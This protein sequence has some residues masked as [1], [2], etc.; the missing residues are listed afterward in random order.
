MNDMALNCAGVTAEERLCGYNGDPNA[1]AGKLFIKNGLRV[2]L[3]RNLD[4]S[5]GFVNGAMATVE[6]VLCQFTLY[7]IRFFVWIVKLR[8]V[9][10]LCN[11]NPF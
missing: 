11:K 3:S 5:R 8:C 4:K 2:R 1:N 6:T 7:Y 10:L 9:L